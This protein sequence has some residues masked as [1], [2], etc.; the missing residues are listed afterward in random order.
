M[1]ALALWLVSTAIVGLA[2]IVAVYGV[3]LV[4]IA[5]LFVAALPLA[6]LQHVLAE[7]REGHRERIRTRGRYFAPLPRTAASARSL[8]PPPYRAPSCRLR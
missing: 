1:I 4:V 3:T 6:Y 8:A 5:V 7:C 2:G